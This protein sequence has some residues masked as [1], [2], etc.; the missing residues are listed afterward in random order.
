[1]QLNKIRQVEWNGLENHLVVYFAAETAAKPAATGLE[2]I[3]D[4]HALRQEDMLFIGKE[5]LDRECA[6]NA[7][8]DFLELNKL[9][10]I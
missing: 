1:M 8:I 6:S 2:L 3:M 5:G 10:S 4:K 9:L 7:K